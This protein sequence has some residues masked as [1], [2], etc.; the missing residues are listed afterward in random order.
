VQWSIAAPL[1]AAVLS[2]Q[3]PA[4][5]GT[6]VRTEFRVFDGKAEVTAVTRLRVVP[7]GRRDAAA[8]AVQLPATPLAPALYDV[9]ARR[10]DPAGV[11]SIKWAERLAVMYYPDEG[12]QHLEVI[13]FQPG[14]GA[15]QLRG[16]S[17]RLPPAAVTLFR[18][19]ERTAPA[20]N[21]IP[22]SDYVLFVVPAGRYDVRITTGDQIRWLTG[23]D[24]PADR[25]R[26]VPIGEL[27][28]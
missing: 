14:F 17:G 20:A 24:V 7:A 28:R 19:G 4:P 23:L 13:N 8:R 15:L 16:T 26:F 1:L 27:D 2:A 5:G 25:T 6:T 12:G 22:G 3:V 10:L 9:E 21:P 18:A 11:I